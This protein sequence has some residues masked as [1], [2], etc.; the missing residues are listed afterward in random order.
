MWTDF[1]E[2]AYITCAWPIAVLLAFTLAG[3]IAW[4]I[5]SLLAQYLWPGKWPHNRGPFDRGS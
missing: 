2:A 3:G 4:G 1:Q 5:F